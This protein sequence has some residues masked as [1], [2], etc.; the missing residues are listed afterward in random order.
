MKSP[1]NARVTI[2]SRVLIFAWTLEINCAIFSIDLRDSIPKKGASECNIV[3]WETPECV[4][5]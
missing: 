3:N 4:F 5:Q 2:N 1:N